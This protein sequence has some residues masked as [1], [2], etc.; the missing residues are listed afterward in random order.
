[1]AATMHVEVVSAERSLLS[2]EATEVY[3]RSLD[4]EIGILPGHQPAL[5]ALDIAPVKVK[6]ADG[7]E[8]RIAVHNGFLY[9]RR[10]R[11]V[12]LADVAEV[13][14]QIDTARA[15]ARLRQLEGRAEDA[16]RATTEASIRKQQVRLSVGD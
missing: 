12:I 1:M 13:A 5:L 4:G 3:A 8:E 9:F 15:Q 11:L 16:E 6:L 14:S 10:D 2:V 7:G